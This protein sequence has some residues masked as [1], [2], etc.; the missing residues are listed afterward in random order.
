MAAREKRWR[1]GAAGWLWLLAIVLALAVALLAV[2][3]CRG[4]SSRGSG[5]AV[6]TTAPSSGPGATGPVNSARATAGDLIV[7]GQPLAYAGAANGAWTGQVGKSVRTSAAP[8][9]AV[10]GDEVFWVGS[11]MKRVLVHLTHTS[12][13][14][15]PTV[16][17]GDHVSFTGSVAANGKRDTQIFGITKQEDAALYN[18]EKVH[19][20]SNVST[21]KVQS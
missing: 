17:T 10:V 3:G 20:E 14:S 2:K 15:A 4:S 12:G 11:G 7:N 9:V 1:G 13:E 21:L 6:G 8:V 5:N 18:R 16:K 19:V